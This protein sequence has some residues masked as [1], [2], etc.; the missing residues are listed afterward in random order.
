MT[1]LLIPVFLQQIQAQVDTIRLSIVSQYLEVKMD[2]RSVPMSVEIKGDGIELAHRPKNVV[3]INGHSNGLRILLINNCDREKPIDLAMSGENIEGVKD[4]CRTVPSGGS[5]LCTLN[6]R[7]FNVDDFVLT[8]AASSGSLSAFAN[9]TCTAR[10]AY[11]I[12][13]TIEHFSRQPPGR[14]AAERDMEVL[15][16]LPCQLFRVDGPGTWAIQR[17]PD[18]YR[19]DEADWQ[20]HRIKKLG[21]KIVMLCGYVPGW[22]KFDPHEYT[23]EE[24][25]SFLAQYE[26]Y[27]TELVGRYAGEVD[28]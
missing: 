15:R 2:E 9:I 24:L 28:Y 5:R 8:I 23:K 6:F 10:V 17:D 4:E 21:A 20:V 16:D 25:N 7:S 26:R 22:I 14:K 18:R 12:F 1:I 3:A 13:G 11:P 27:L 19:W